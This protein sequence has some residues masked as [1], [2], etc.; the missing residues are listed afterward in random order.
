MIESL[1]NGFETT[2]DS[3]AT[4]VQNQLQTSESREALRAGLG[5]K[6]VETILRGTRNKESNIDDVY[7]VYLYKDGLM[8]GN[9]KTFRRE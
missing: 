4:K 1:E 3:F 5:Q 8:F 7:G 9:K 2:E 6:Y